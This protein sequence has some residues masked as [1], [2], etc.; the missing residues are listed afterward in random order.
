MTQRRKM[1]DALVI[2]TLVALL[3]MLIS[4][5][6]LPRAAKAHAVHDSLGASTRVHTAAESLA[7]RPY[8]AE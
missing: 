8:R 6:V 7:P 1:R 4:M 5:I 3:A 2:A